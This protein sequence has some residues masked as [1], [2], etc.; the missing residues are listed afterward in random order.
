MT[1][2]LWP[3]QHTLADHA[4]LPEAFED[5]PVVWE[6][7]LPAHP[8]ASS[9]ASLTDTGC[10]DVDAVDLALPC[11]RVLLSGLRHNYND[12]ILSYTFIR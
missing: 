7:V 10:L 12:V 5:T 9:P 4:D 8:P 6:E 2:L 3:E 1:T 11:G